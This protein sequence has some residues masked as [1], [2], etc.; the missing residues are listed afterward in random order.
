MLAHE[1]AMSDRDERSS[2]SSNELDNFSA[3]PENDTGA[4]TD[5]SGSDDDEAPEAVSMG[6]AQ[7]MVQ[8]AEKRKEIHLKEEQKK[9]REKKLRRAEKQRQ[10]A[11]ASLEKR[12]KKIEYVAEK[13]EDT[14]MKLTDTISALPLDLL[15]QAEAAEQ[16]VSQS[17]NT[18]V[19]FSGIFTQENLEDYDMT[20]TE[21]SDGNNDSSAGTGL[22]DT[23]RSL[24][25]NKKNDQSTREIQGIQVAVLPKG[26]SGLYG[27]DKSVT[28]EQLAQLREFRRSTHIPRFDFSR[29]KGKHLYLLNMSEAGKLNPTAL[30]DRFYF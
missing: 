12:K 26:N 23:A 13:A 24:Q 20:N 11:E 16:G 1:H 27:E 5:D 30:K 2:P 14:A 9:L 21:E 18:H 15:E 4:M 28:V 10:K 19:K 6:A 25:T 17:A 8:M 3:V 22:L 7:S 29:N